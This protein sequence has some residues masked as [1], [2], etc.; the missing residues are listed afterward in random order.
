MGVSALNNAAIL[1]VGALHLL[2]LRD[3][4]PPGALLLYPGQILH[5]MTNEVHR[6]LRAWR[7]NDTGN[8]M[9]I[10]VCSAKAL[11]F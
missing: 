3:L 10:K 5:R 8:R 2:A 9:L 6:C 11:K 1:Y 7:S 4:L